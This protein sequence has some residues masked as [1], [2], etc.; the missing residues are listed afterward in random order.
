MLIISEKMKINLESLFN[1]N[2]EIDRGNQNF[3]STGIRKQVTDD[4]PQTC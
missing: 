1:E 3:H 2:L 4:L